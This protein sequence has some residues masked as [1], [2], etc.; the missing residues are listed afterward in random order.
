MNDDLSV[1]EVC[2]EHVLLCSWASVMLGVCGL[3][4]RRLIAG[5][6]VGTNRGRWSV[7]HGTMGDLTR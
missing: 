5:Q 2:G 1:I 7:Y 6:V 3:G 4:I